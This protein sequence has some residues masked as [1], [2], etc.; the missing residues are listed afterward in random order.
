MTSCLGQHCPGT[1]PDSPPHRASWFS[2][3]CL[4]FP[5]CQMG[6]GKPCLLGLSGIVHEPTDALRWVSGVC[7]LLLLVR[8]MYLQGLLTMRQQP[9][10]SYFLQNPAAM[11]TRA[12]SPSPEACSDLCGAEA[13][14]WVCGLAGT[15]MT[16]ETVLALGA[17]P[18]PALCHQICP[19]S[20]MPGQRH[21]GLRSPGQT[22]SSQANFR[23]DLSTQL[24]L[25][26][27]RRGRVGG[28]TGRSSQR[29][30]CV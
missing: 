22:W 20:P 5:I 1:N 14:V 16:G 24:L 10:F 21:P 3:M 4:S 25:S 27:W 18:S 6:M 26:H 23:N 7:Q 13:G 9:E 2:F 11:E 19:W 30:G 8:H 12:P 17:V 15:G 29:R 28:G